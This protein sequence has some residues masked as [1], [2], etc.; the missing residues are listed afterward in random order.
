MKGI[1]DRFEE[2]KAIIELEN[3]TKIEIDKDK[4]PTKAKEGD[5]ILIKEDKIIIDK[6][7]TNDR[8][9]YI[10]KITMDLWE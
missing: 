10:E 1:I 2:K 8:K 7:A 9:K 3:R 6:E 4:L 5:C